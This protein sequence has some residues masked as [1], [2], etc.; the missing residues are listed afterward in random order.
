VNYIN[1]PKEAPLAQDVPEELWNLVITEKKNH[2]ATSSQN[3]KITKNYETTCKHN[4][5]V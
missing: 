4:K 2:V 3:S 1:N 5:W